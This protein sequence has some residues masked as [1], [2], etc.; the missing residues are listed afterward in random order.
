MWMVILAVLLAGLIFGINV[1][2]P[3]GQKVLGINVS[4]AELL[5]TD[6]TAAHALGTR[7][8]GEDGRC[9]IYGKHGGTTT[10]GNFVKIDL[11][12]SS[13]PFSF[14]N[15]AAATDII[16]GIACASGTDGVYG[17]FQVR[18]K[19]TSANVATGVS[20]GA[21]LIA[22]STAG[23]AA[24]YANTDVVPIAAIAY[25]DSASNLGDVYILGLF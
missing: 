24:A 16:A 5:L 15:T 2:T 20:A 8:Y 14:I 25:N 21:G 6:T 7:I 12:D 9:Y 10:A 18:G 22:T 4:S 1:P 19:Y 3:T 17:W 11:A 13:E 23:R